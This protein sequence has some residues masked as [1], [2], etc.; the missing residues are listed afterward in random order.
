MAYE[1]LAGGLGLVIPT[2]GQTNWGTVIK[3]PTWKKLNDHAHTGGGDGNQIGSGAIAANSIDKSKLVLNLGL[4]QA[5]T[6]T[7]AGISETIDFDLGNKQILDLSSATGTVILT[8][9]NPIEGASYRVKVIQGGTLR[10]LT[11]PAN[12]KWPQGEE[13]SQFHEI[14]TENMVYLDYDGADY[15]VRWELNLS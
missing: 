14:N 1:T 13:F 4:Y 6:L 10:A 5:V 3:S 12:V 8:L 7:P 15:L 9:S 11:W 2:S